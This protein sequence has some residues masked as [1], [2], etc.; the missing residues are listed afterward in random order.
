[1]WD[2]RLEA[3]PARRQLGDDGLVQLAQ[4]AAL[5]RPVANVGPPADLSIFSLSE[6]PTRPGTA[7]PDASIPSLGSLRLLPTGDDGIPT[8]AHL[9]PVPPHLSNLVDLPLPRIR[10]QL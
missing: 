9:Q 5:T 1:M 8:L 2:P 6:R 4:I 3:A 7:R 10:D